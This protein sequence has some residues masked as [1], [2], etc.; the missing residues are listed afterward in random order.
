MGHAHLGCS[1]ALREG[2]LRANPFP[3][4][5][6]AAWYGFGRADLYCLA[7]SGGLP[8]G[9]DEAAYERG[10]RDAVAIDYGPGILSLRIY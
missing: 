10:R 7:F 4:A 8:S 5:T 9:A 2:L 1:D 6:S 3:E